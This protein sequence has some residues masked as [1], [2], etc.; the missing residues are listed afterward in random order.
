MRCPAPLVV[1]VAVAALA[2]KTAPLAKAAPEPDSQLLPTGARI[3]PTASPGARFQ[4]L[5]P[6]PGILAGMAVATSLSPDGATLLVLTSGYNRHNGPDGERDA[7]AST[8]HVFVFD[9]R[10]QV[11]E[12]KQVL[13]IANSFQG[14]AWNPDGRSFYVSGG[15][16]DLVHL[17]TRGEAG[18]REE[19][20]PILLGHAQ[21]LGLDRVRPMAAGLATDGQTLIVANYENDSISIVDLGTRSKVAELELR[22]GKIAAQ[23]RGIAGGEYPIAVALAG[24]RAF[25]SCL[26]DGEVVEVDLAARRVVRR[27]RTGRQPGRLLLDKAQARLFVVNGGSD[28]VSVVEVASGRILAELKTAAPPPLQP[29]LGD[30]KGANPNSLALSAD[31]ETLYVSN[32]GTNT[33]AVIDLASQSVRGLVPT[34]WYPHS[35]SIGNGTLYIA[36]GKSPT[37][38]AAKNCR[39]TLEVPRPRGPDKAGQLPLACR[40]NNQYVLQLVHGGLLSLPIP[41]DLAALTATAARNNG[42]IQEGPDPLFAELRQRIHHVIYVVKENR[43]FDQVLGDLGRGNGDPGLTLFPERTTPNHHALARGFVTL[44]AFF[45]SGEVSGDGWNWSTAGRASDVTEKAIQVEYADRGLSYDYEGANRNLNVG[46]ANLAERRAANPQTPEDPDLL[47]GDADVAAPGDYLWSRAL[48]AGLTLRNY[49]FFSDDTR[50]RRDSPDYLPTSQ[51]PFKDRALQYISTKRELRDNSDPY[52]RSFDQAWPDYWNYKEWEREFDGYAEKG[53]LPALE[54]VRFSH[55]HFGSFAAAVDGVNTPETQMADND[56]ALGLLVEKIAASRFANDTVIFVLEDDAQDGPDHVDAHRSL[57]LVAGAYVRQ[58]ALV[59]QPHT[60]VSVLRTIELLLGLLPMGLTDGLAHP[61]T[62][63]FQRDF[64]PWSF[65]AQV[66]APL[67][68]TRLPLPP[69]PAAA[70]GGATQ[71]TRPAHDAQWWETQTAGQDFTR[72]DALDSDAFSRTLWRGLRDDPY[73]GD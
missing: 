32:G 20:A 7:A 45:D 72:A 35:V 65:K 10:A 26:R 18:Y 54:L 28:T 36:N 53:N 62:E 14:L 55:D 13:P 9:V 38:P 22:P 12:E 34:G 56:Y 47:P 17:F 48:Q 27:I 40:A 42:F 25:V 59:S 69:G 61:M 4:T 57:A 23:D 44:D 24:K 66:P 1:V 8:E 73:P 64:A 3:T 19:A 49:G 15:V 68:A 60:T 52:F 43:T 29:G 67:R 21:G 6:L 46:I 41:A 16:D 5:S 63:V 50:Y 30:L 71:V 51:T 33:V 37:G 39:N 11:P 58:G 31:E 70:N 2:C